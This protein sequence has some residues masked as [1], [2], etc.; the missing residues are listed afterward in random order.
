MNQIPQFFQDL[1]VNTTRAYCMGKTIDGCEVYIPLADRSDKYTELKKAQLQKWLDSQY[2]P[3]TLE[4]T[5][6]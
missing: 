6:A 3:E 5:T 1:P 2:V 4:P